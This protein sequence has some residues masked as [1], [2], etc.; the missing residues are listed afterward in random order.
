MIEAFEDVGEF[1][2]PGK[3]K[4]KKGGTLLYS[5]GERPKLRLSGSFKS[6]REE[7]QSFGAFKFRAPE[8]I[9]L[10]RTARAGNVTLYESRD[11]GGKTVDL[12][13]G[14]TIEKWME[15]SVLFRGV[16]FE[17]EGSIRFDSV[18]AELAHLD[19]WAW[20]FVV[21]PRECPYDRDSRMQTLR[22][23]HPAS[24][25]V[26][27]SED[28]VASLGVSLTGPVFTRPQ[29]GLEVETRTWL[30]LVSPAAR[31]LESFLKKLW[32]WSS[33]VSLATQQPVFPTRLTGKPSSQGEEAA[34]SCPTGSVEIAYRDRRL[35]AP[36]PDLSPPHDMLFSLRDISRDPSFYI[37][38]WEDA[39]EA[40]RPVLNLYFA[41]LEQEG[42]HLEPR[43]LRLIQ[44][45]EGYHRRVLEGIGL[46][47]TEHE[48]RVQQILC[49]VPRECVKWLK[50]KLKHS[51]EPNLGARLSALC[52]RHMEMMKR[53]A[54]D[55]S[56][57]DTAV[58]IRNDYSHQKQDSKNY[59][60]PEVL[61]VSER[62]KLLLD[63]CLLSECGFSFAEAQKLVS[64]HWESHP[65]IL[66]IDAEKAL[67]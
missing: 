17:N 24:V 31:D 39:T 44:A 49:S 53:V 37:R 43:F 41:D 12:E 30:R 51:N 16:H 23:R 14:G 25:E 61:T 13:Y 4:A 29:K 15:A 38:S 33:F 66:A 36:I 5:P 58:G 42:V 34:S 35:E 47:E 32:V 19:E 48:E 50:G 45:L 26:K 8:K 7:I 3:E 60:V 54:P 10:G 21:D 52:K 9:V 62:L 65:P 27:F 63:L 22:Y 67:I 40:L 55:K 18:T 28:W 57:I 20:L 64:R 11:T 1:W 56:W 59:E 46:S 6:V 2:L